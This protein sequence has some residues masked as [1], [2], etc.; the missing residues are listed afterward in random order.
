[1][2][3]PT[4]HVPL[5]RQALILEH[6]RL[7][8]DSG[9]TKLDS[10][11][12]RSESLELTSI[13]RQAESFCLYGTLTGRLSSGRPATQSIPRTVDRSTSVAALRDMLFMQRFGQTRDQMSTALQKTSSQLS[14]LESRAQLPGTPLWGQP[15]DS[16]Q[17]LFCYGRQFGKYF[18]GSILMGLARQ[19]DVPLPSSFVSWESN[20]SQSSPAETPSAT[21]SGK[22]GAS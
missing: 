4:K 10:T 1:M 20:P 2:S 9:F 11:Q 12:S 5:S 15:S 17:S 22:S 18:F 6:G 14:K 7:L 16:T 8:Q 13:S 21:A 19:Q 3:Y